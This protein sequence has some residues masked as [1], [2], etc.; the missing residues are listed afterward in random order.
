M[1]IFLPLENVNLDEVLFKKAI[2]N[3]FANYNKFYKIMYNLQYFTLNSLL[4]VV[5]IVQAT[6][7]EEYNRYRTTIQLDD[8]VVEKIKSL[9][10]MILNKINLETKKNISPSTQ[11]NNT[12]IFCISET[13]PPQSIRKLYVRVSGVWESDMCIGLTTK[14]SPNPSEV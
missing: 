7:T 11:L 3:K 10:S 2:T 12:R 1:N 13:C 5:P 4:V 9:E 14:Y 8:E 6:V